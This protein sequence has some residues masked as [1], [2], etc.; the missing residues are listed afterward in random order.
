VPSDR[1]HDSIGIILGLSW[2]LVA[3]ATEQ[4]LWVIGSVSFLIGTFFLSPDLDLMSD[5]YRRWGPLRIIWYPYRR[6]VNHRSWISH[7]P[8]WGTAIRI[9]WLAVVSLPVLGV[10]GL[11]NVVTLDRVISWLSG[12][13]RGVFAALVGLE[14]SSLVH[15]FAD[16]VLRYR[17]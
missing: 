6:L 3:L 7:G 16:I 1:T 17:R 8:V 11:L 10:L 12:H 13:P 2:L 14:A 15:L 5:H 4:P 9:A